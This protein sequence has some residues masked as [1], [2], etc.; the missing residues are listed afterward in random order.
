MIG[1]VSEAPEQKAAPALLRPVIFH[2]I[3]LRK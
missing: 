2:R 1:R 3:I